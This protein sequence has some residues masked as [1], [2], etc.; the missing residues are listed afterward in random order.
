M[1]DSHFTAVTRTLEKGQSLFAFT[2]GWLEPEVQLPRYSV[3]HG[4]IR[5]EAELIV[6]HTEGPPPTLRGARISCAM[7]ASFPA[8]ELLGHSA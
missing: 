8:Q 6:F 3:P 7:P 1:P 5:Q 4:C 2:D